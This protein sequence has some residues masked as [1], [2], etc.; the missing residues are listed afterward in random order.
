MRWCGMGSPSSS[1]GSSEVTVAPEARTPFTA[2][3]LF[4]VIFTTVV[5]FS[6]TDVAIAA[7]FD[8]NP[9]MD[10]SRVFRSSERARADALG[11]RDDDRLGRE[12][13]IALATLEPF[14]TLPYAVC[15]KPTWPVQTHFE[16][17]FVSFI[18][19]LGC[20]IT[21]VAA[22]QKSSTFASDAIG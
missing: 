17:R 14:R 10:A 7:G 20:P 16:F 21:C 15:H 18:S 3:L 11:A 19:A 12:L 13:A 5:A 6:R 22:L 1:V 8:V 4:R 9:L 2:G